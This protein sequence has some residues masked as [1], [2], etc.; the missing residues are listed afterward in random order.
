MKWLMLMMFLC[1]AAARIHDDELVVVA[2]VS[3]DGLRRQYLLLS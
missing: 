3:C 1:T 2:A